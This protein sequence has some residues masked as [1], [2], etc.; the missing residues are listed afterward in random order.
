MR[1]IVKAIEHEVGRGAPL[2]RVEFRDPYKYKRAKELFIA[3]EGMFTLLCL[4]R[5]AA[6]RAVLMLALVAAALIE[7]VVEPV[8]A[9]PAP[10]APKPA[11]AGKKKAQ[12]DLAVFFRLSRRN[13][14]QFQHLRLAVALKQQQIGR[15]SCRERV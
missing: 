11:A 9:A 14:V 4:L 6:P 10:A 1:G 3:P 7:P 12:A 8:R 13:Q 15:A 2:A 5:R